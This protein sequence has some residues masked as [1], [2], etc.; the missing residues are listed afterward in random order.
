ME[1]EPSQ[2][3]I[4]AIEALQIRIR[5]LE[6]EEKDLTDEITRYKHLVDEND[7]VRQFREQKYQEMVEKG[8][9]MMEY[10]Q[11]I[12]NDKDK[13][14]E[15]NIR[16]RY[17]LFN[18]ETTFPFLA[19]FEPGQRIKLNKKQIRYLED[20][21]L[22]DYRILLHE[23]AAPR[24]LNISKD[25]LN[26]TIASMRTSPSL[27]KPI[28]SLVDKLMRAPKNVKS[29]PLKKK[30]QTMDLILH[31]RDKATQISYKISRL[32]Q[33]SVIKGTPHMHDTD[34]STLYKSYVL[35][36][37]ELEKFVF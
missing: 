9:A 19:D 37:Q 35:I 31:A 5:E 12:L 29:M 10:S 6:K 28:S 27:P 15:E 36:T 32:Y 17:E 13:A 20:D 23:T 30:I 24:C 26:Y 11:E 7:E 4:S 8:Q 25:V 18:I 14:R 2:A 1:P 33:K 34:I 21:P 22:M 16:L 3:A